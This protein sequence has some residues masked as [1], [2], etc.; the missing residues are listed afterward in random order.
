MPRPKG[1]VKILGLPDKIVDPEKEKGTENRQKGRGNFSNRRN[2]K[3][4]KRA[5]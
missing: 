4:R 2:E 1:H 3:G 5:R